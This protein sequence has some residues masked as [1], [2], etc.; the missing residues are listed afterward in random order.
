MNA[1]RRRHS[2]DVQVVF[3][4]PHMR[5]GAGNVWRVWRCCMPLERP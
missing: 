4:A 3:L 2:G 5:D 1:R